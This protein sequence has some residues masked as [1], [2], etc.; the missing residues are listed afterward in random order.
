MSFKGLSDSL[1]IFLA[2]F[3]ARKGNLSERVTREHFLI[4]SCLHPCTALARDKLASAWGHAVWWPWAQ[5]L[6]Q[7]DVR[8]GKPGCAPWNHLNSLGVPVSRKGKLAP[9]DRLKRNKYAHT[10]RHKVSACLFVL[11]PYNEGHMQ[12]TPKHSV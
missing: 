7:E 4:P 9:Q 12:S 8:S 2:R 3:T 6:C 1:H 10:D 5:L 11:V